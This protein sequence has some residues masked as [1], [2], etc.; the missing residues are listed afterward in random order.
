MGLELKSKHNIKSLLLRGHIAN[1]IWTTLNGHTI[2][3]AIWGPL[4]N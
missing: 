1:N 3:A 4:D 2:Q